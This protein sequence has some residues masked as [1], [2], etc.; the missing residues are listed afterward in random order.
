MA[1][2]FKKI[3]LREYRKRLSLMFVCAAFF[4]GVGVFLLIISSVKSASYTKKAAGEVTGY[5]VQ[6]HRHAKLYVEKYEYIP[7]V[8]FDVDGVTVTARALHVALSKGYSVGQKV[9][10]RYNPSD[11]SAVVIVG[12]YTTVLC[13]LST[14]LFGAIFVAAFVTTLRRREL[15]LLEE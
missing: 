10:V 13:A 12:D 9:T 11:L 14:F 6:Y 5:D 4:I 2:K 7:I 3:T 15:L 1:S 8:S